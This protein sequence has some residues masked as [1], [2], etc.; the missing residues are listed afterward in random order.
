MISRR[1][2]LQ[3]SGAALA[4]APFARALADATSQGAADEFFV[5]IHAAGGWDVTLWADPRNE[6][7]GIIEPASTENTDT[8]P[9]RRWKDQALEGGAASFALVTAPGSRLV[10]GPGIGNLLDH[11]DRLCVVNGL[12]MNTVSHPDGTCYSATGR[13]LQGGRSV[14][15]SIN[16]ALASE[17]GAAQTLPS[18]SV[19]FPSFYAGEGL[20]R[21]AVPLV[22]ERIGSIGRTLARSALYESADDRAAVTAVLSDEARQLAER[23]AYPGALDGMALQYGALRRML[24]PEMQDLLSENRLRTLYPRFNYKGRFHG[25]TCVNA[26]FAVEAMKR[27]VVRCVSFALGGF[28]THAINYRQQALVQQDVFDLVATLI[29]TLDVTPHPTHPTE[30]LSEHTHI[31]VVSDFCRTPQIN[32]GGGR[33]HYPNNSALVVSPRFR[34][35]FVFGRSDPGQLLPSE[36]KQFADGARP[37]EPPDLLATFL[38]A[39][40]IAPRKYLR[41][42]E[43]VPELLRV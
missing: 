43:V 26:A 17:L 28:D 42:G 38:S 36:A 41:D 13:H 37:I 11:H 2:F 7:K 32:I 15:S 30:M 9:I 20:D 23:S 34:G 6:K 4:L 16:T 8:A 1:R 27:N 3:W 10:F 29:E 22:V 5:F 40:G 25:P 24:T 35:D 31:L 39:F 19:Q 18:V 12:A 33:D 21:R 14:Q